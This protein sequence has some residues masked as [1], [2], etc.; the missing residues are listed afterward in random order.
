MKKNYEGTIG[1]YNFI[2]VDDTTIEVWSDFDNEN[3][4]SFIFV[5]A[6]AISNEKQFHYEISDWYLKN[7]G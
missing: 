4:E 5:K 3:P 7:V 1:V 2:M 6:G